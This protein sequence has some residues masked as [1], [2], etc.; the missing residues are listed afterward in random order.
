MRGRFVAI[1]QLT[2]VIGILLAQIIN[3]N[4]AQDVPA[5]FTDLQILESWNGQ[6]AWLWMFW[7]ETLF[8]GLFFVLVFFIPE[9]PRW[10]VKA[11]FDG[12]ATSILAKVGG[13]KYGI[14]SHQSIKATLEKETAK[15]TVTVSPL[16]DNLFSNFLDTSRGRVYFPQS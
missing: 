15:G 10:L 1:N 13:A 8:A 5:G 9:S 7:A 16:F 4:I 3:L 14:K 6:N 12:R 11:G 2:I